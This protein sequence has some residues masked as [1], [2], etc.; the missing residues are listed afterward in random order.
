M[1]PSQQV[2][3]EAEGLPEQFE[4]VEPDFSFDVESDGSF[5]A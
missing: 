5:H 3:A 1:L 2:M 4:R